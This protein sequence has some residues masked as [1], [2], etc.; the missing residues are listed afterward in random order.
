MPLRR[1]YPTL[2]TF[3][4]L[5]D[6]QIRSHAIFAEC[7]QRRQ[8]PLKAMGFSLIWKAKSFK[9]SNISYLKCLP[10]PLLLFAFAFVTIS[11]QNLIVSYYNI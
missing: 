8:S 11:P 6:G 1:N 7:L 10:P 3:Q 5:L 2:E 9:V 4:R